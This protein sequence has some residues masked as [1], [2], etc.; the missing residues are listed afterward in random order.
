[1]SYQE[2][3]FTLIEIL[4]VLAIMGLV[5]T[6]VYSLHLTGWQVW[7]FNQQKVSNHQA[8]MIM[9]TRLMKDIRAAS[10]VIIKD[11]GSDLRLKISDNS[12]TDYVRYVVDDNYLYYAKHEGI[13]WP[14]RWNLDRR[15]TDV[16][17]N[18][19]KCV[20]QEEN[21]KILITIN[22]SLGTGKEKYTLQ[23]QVYLRN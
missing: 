5:M 17:V 2:E 22:L 3:G 9:M 11:N 16:V 6:A 7:N 20:K 8:G 19:F 21:N 4:I 10:E 18:N 1:M 23:N 15:I 12:E 14:T 13:E